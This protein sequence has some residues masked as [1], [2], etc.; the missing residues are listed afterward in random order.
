MSLRDYGL[1]DPTPIG[2]PTWERAS[3]D[4]PP[5]PNCGGHLC[6][7]KVEAEVAQLRGGKGTCTYLGCPACPYASPSVTSAAPKK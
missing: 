2:T 7:V 1:P 6:V 4:T 3:A 5:C